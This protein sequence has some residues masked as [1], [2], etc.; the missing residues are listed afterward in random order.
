AGRL[1]RGEELL[2]KARRGLE[3]IA[4]DD[5]DQMRPGAWDHV[6][7]RIP[8]AAEREPA[9]VADL[10]GQLPHQQHH[11]ALR[12]EDTDRSASGSSRW[13]SAPCWVTSSVGR[14]ARTSAGTVARMARTHPSAVVRE[15]SG[16]LIAVPGAPGPPE[17][18]MK[19]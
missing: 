8:A 9:P 18:W 13:L 5:R 14:T 15:G 19:P 10:V 3:G 11:L 7:D 6:D 17:S 4:G 16:R 1:G 2:R 12:L